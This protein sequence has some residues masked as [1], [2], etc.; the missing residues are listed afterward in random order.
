MKKIRIILISL[1]TIFTLSLTSCLN[2]LEDFVGDFSSSPAIAELSEA[3]NAATG[4]VVREIIDPT[5][6]A[7][8]TLRV[9]IASADYF[10]KDVTVT[11]EIDNT[12]ISDYNTDKGL[13]GSD[14][15]IPVPASALSYTSLTVTIPAGER[16][17]DWEF[18]VDAAQVPDPVSKFYVVPVKIASASDGIVVSGNYGS[19]LVR[20][21][22]RNKYDGIYEV[23]AN[24]PMIDIVATYLSGNYPFHYALITTGE[25]TCDCI[26]VEDDYP[27]H[28]ILNGTAWSYY[29]SFCPQVE[30]KSDGSNEL[31]Q[32][33]NYYGNPASNTRGCL[34]DDSQAWGIVSGTKNIRLKYYMTMSSAVPDPPHI[35]TTFDETWTYVGPRD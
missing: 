30:F 11:L 34:L 25:Y 19:K 21:L 4:T 33:T 28:P 31:L 23:T 26:E 13:T 5:V 6:P 35:R 3:P 10:S 18:T 29:G 8:F 16:E 7:E 2:D 9:N 32:M 15:A 20:I 1:L 17:V 14:A 27:L 24:S 12:L 22:A